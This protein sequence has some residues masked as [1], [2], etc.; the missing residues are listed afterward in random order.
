[1]AFTEPEI[2]QIRDFL[3]LDPEELCAGSHLRSRLQ[4]IEERDARCSIDIEGA[5]RGYLVAIAAIDTQILASDSSSTPVGVIRREEIDQEQEIEY[6]NSTISDPVAY[7]QRE[8]ARLLGK[9]Y[10]D[11]GL[12]RPTGSA[13]RMRS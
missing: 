1:M 5:I 12:M 4:Y 11:L 8:R 10:R 2:N 6:Q 13:L 3:E 7:M 9:L